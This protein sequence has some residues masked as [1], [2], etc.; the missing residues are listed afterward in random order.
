MKRLSMII[1]ILLIA[2]E[3]AA[4]EQ[5]ESKKMTCE[6]LKAALRS[7]GKALI[8]YPS[9]RVAGMTRYDMYVGGKQFCMRLQ[10]VARA[11][12]PTS[13]TKSCVVERCIHYGKGSVSHY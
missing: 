1:P 12:V 4:L 10:F 3:A 6:E 5:L 2:G 7:E 9:S 8:R 13:D 11:T